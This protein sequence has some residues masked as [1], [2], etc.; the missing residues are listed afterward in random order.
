[1]AKTSQVPRAGKSIPEFCEAYGISPRTFENW[2]RKGI[3]PAVIQPAGPGGRG[4]ISPEAEAAWK[5]A[6]SGLAA[7]VESAA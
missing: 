6:A 3:G 4:F 5:R 2:R 7:A 1:M